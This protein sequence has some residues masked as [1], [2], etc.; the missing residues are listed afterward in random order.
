MDEMVGILQRHARSNDM[1]LFSPEVTISI[2]STVER[3]QLLRQIILDYYLSYDNTTQIELHMDRYYP[4]FLKELGILALR[5]LHS[6]EPRASSS[7]EIILDAENCAYHYHDP[8]C[9]KKSCTNT[10]GVS[11]QVVSS[12]SAHAQ[13]YV[14]HNFI[15][16]QT[17]FPSVLT[18][19]RSLDVTEEVR[20]VIN[21]W[22]PER[23]AAFVVPQELLTEKSEFFRTTCSKEVR[24][25]DGPHIMIQ[26]V[27]PEIFKAYLHW[28][29]RGMVAVSS[30][31]DGQPRSAAQAEPTI[32]ELVELW[33]LADRFSD[34][35][36]RNSTMDAL[37]EVAGSIY[38]ADAD[39]TAAFPPSMTVRIWPSTTKGRALRRFVVDIYQSRVTIEILD[40]VRSSCHP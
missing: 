19:I 29:Y 38:K 7:T 22:K 14:V 28:V 15:P 32:K 3:G 18:S 37:R 33:L 2:W 11:T 13:T 21:E 31:F 40:Q 20:I 9:P 23:T 12:G 24:L 30:G 26:D 1:A 17:V 39:W 36:L 34:S 35:K 8:G 6:R 4:E 25:Y 5:T 27:D 10:G 16:I